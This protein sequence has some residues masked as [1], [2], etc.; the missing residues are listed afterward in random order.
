MMLRARTTGQP[1][2]DN[3]KLA[4]APHPQCYRCGGA[5]RFLEMLDQ[6][7]YGE[8]GKALAQYLCE[9]C[10]TLIEELRPV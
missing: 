5:T 1:Y 9:S 10:H 6:P 7:V 2:R 3:P 8:P 4:G